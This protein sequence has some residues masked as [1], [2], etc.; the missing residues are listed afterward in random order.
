MYSIQS[1]AILGA[2]TADLFTMSVVV[3]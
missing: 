1:S 3:H 2:V